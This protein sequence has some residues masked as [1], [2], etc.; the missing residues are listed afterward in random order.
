MFL[1]RLDR[2]CT[3]H[4]QDGTEVGCSPP[5][6]EAC[7]A[8]PHSRRFGT[9]RAEPEKGL[10]SV[11]PTQCVGR[12]ARRGR[13]VG[14]LGSDSA[15]QEGCPGSLCSQAWEPGPSLYKLF[16]QV[17]LPV[18]VSP[19]VAQTHLESKDGTI[20]VRKNPTSQG[21]AGSRG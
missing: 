2:P 15:R 16:F 17:E 5:R 19:G 1:P 11:P 14:R 6:A 9:F 13:P 12:W 8:P 20:N 7:R 10:P 4:G 18:S 21:W 3:L